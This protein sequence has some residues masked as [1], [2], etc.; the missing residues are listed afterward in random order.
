MFHI[1]AAKSSVRHVSAELSCVAELFEVDFPIT[2]DITKF[3]HLFDKI[4][5]LEELLQ[6]VSADFSA[7]VLVNYIE[8]LS[9]LRE[10][11]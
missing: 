6:L 8:S 4:F 1:I 9:Q 11:Y 7:A 5:V 3:E 10:S 2:V